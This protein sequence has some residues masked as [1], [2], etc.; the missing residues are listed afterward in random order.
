MNFF[1][2]ACRIPLIVHAPE[3]FLPHRVSESAS[4]LDILPTLVDLA[5][6]GEALAYAAPI[7]GRSLLPALEGGAGPGQVVGEYLAEG[8]VAPIVM[9]SEER[10]V[11]QECR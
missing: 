9:R 8:A 4:L 10:R 11:G 1:E 6:E 2:N 7:D 5:S 3:R